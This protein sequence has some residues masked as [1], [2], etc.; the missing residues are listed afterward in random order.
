MK[1]NFFKSASLSVALG[2]LAPTASLGESALNHLEPEVKV[3][4][5]AS[6]ETQG[7]GTPNL[8]SAGIFAPLKLNNNWILFLDGE[9][10]VN[11]PDRSDY[12]SIINTTIGGYTLSTS[13]RLGT[14][15]LSDDRQ[16]MW[17]VN[18]GYDSRPITTGAVDHGNYYVKT[19]RNLFYEQLGGE[20]ELRHKNAGLTAYANVPIGDKVQALNA[21]FNGGALETYG[22]DF[23]YFLN[24]TLKAKLGY[25]YQQGDLGTAN[26]SGG[27]AS[28]RW[29]VANGLY[30]KGT[31]T[32]D[33]AF[34]S[35]AT[36]GIEYRFG[37]NKNSRE[38]S[39]PLQAYLEPPGHRLVRIHDAESAQDE[40]KEI[41]DWLVKNC[42]GTTTGKVI[43][44]I[45]GTAAL[46]GTVAGIV[47]LYRM[48]R[49]RGRAGSVFSD[50]SSSSNPFD[51][52]ALSDLSPSEQEEVMGDIRA[53]LGIPASVEVDGVPEALTVADMSYESS[54]KSALGSNSFQ[55]ED[56][57]G[58]RQLISDGLEKDGVPEGLSSEF[59]EGRYIELY[60]EIDFDYDDV[61][62]GLGRRAVVGSQGD[63][64]GDGD[65]G[66][67]WFDDLDL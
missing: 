36:A 21:Y 63:G 62:A 9:F 49:A 6:T 14:R 13:S 57:S 12:S 43:C 58:T 42:A 26:G 61:L 45:A 24:R 30:L 47:K 22:I 31:Y 48:L 15:F 8:S 67:N 52:R 56:K 60:N 7:A 51:E 44:G 18:A 3:Q 1:N 4:A 17:G 5:R 19:G 53:Q 25:Y 38:Y 23:D 41:V 37:A 16:W 33:N 50:D 65:G 28:L 10:G 32:Y 35:R 54:V 27:L 59:V 40:L 11:Y 20:L 46:V 66:E 29:Q 39:A 64:D 2:L 55:I 34:E